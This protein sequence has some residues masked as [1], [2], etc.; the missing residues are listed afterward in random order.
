MINNA[1]VESDARSTQ[2]GEGIQRESEDDEFQRERGVG[3]YGGDSKHSSV[4]LGTESEGEGSG[5]GDDVDEFEELRR[6]GMGE[7]KRGSI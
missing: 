6:G 3:E 1:R 4:P 7:W 5:Y 2:G